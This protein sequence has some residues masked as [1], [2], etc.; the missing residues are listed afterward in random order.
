MT[1]KTE[2]PIE[3]IK[4]ETTPVEQPNNTMQ[5]PPVIP[6]TLTQQQALQVLVDVGN[7]AISKGILN[8]W[9]AEILAKAMRVFIQPAPQGPVQ[10]S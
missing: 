3:E 2:T 10:T 6:E 4:T 7:L 1:N 5:A 8:V 9:E